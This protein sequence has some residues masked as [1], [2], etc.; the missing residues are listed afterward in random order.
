[1]PAG[2]NLVGTYDSSI[3]YGQERLLVAWQ[4]INLPNG[5]FMDLPGMGGA[6]AK[7]AGF[8]DQVDNHYD[9]IWGATILTSLL[10][11]GAQLAQPQQS[12]A[13]Q[14]PG[15]GQTIGQSVG[16]QI[17]QTGTTL[18]NKNLNLQPTLHIRPGFEFTV[19][20]NKDLVFPGAYTA[21]PNKS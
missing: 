21:N 10:A 3:A 6:D 1:L 13:L 19:E 4:R 14:S 16:T 2:A 11:A 5:Q 9:K 7:G 15:V 12:N 18:M 17:A 8:G 20:V